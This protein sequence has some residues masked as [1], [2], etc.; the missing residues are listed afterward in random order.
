MTKTA[1]EKIQEGLVEALSVAKG[2]AEP[3]RMH[4]PPE[5][6]VRAVRQKTNLS[7]DGFASTFGFN[8]AQVRNWEQGRSRPLGAMRAYLMLIDRHPAEIQKLLLEASQGE[9]DCPDIK[10]G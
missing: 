3:A 7:Q 8:I 6:N 2:D 10:Y 9:T 5:I 4:V 1:F